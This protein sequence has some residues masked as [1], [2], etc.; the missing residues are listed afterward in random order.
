MSG[1]ELNPYV[2]RSC[3]LGIWLLRG[4][5]LEP[6]NG[7]TGTTGSMLFGNGGFEWETGWDG[8][9]GNAANDSRVDLSAVALGDVVHIRKNSRH[10]VNKSALE[11]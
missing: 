2:S 5:E 9:Y 7:K 8:R 6:A 1:R 4:L 10:C 3:D 11:K